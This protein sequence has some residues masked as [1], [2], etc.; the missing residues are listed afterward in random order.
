MDTMNYSKV[1]MTDGQSHILSSSKML[2]SGMKKNHVLK[3]GVNGIQ[4]IV[5][6]CNQRAYKVAK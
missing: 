1:A 6:T 3:A 5:N 2:L 4:Y